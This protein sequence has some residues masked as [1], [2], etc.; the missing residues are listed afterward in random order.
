MVYRKSAC[1]AWATFALLFIT[2]PA[3]AKEEIFVYGAQLEEFE[4]RRGSGSSNEKLLAWDGGAFAG[5]DDGK[6]HWLTEGAYDLNENTFAETENRLVAQIP[7]SMFFDVKAGV[8]LDTYSGGRERWYTVFGATGLAPQ[9][10]EL[11]ADLFIGESGRASTRL[12]AEYELLLTNR[13]FATFSMETTYSFAADK[14]VGIGT[15]VTDLEAGMR[16]SYD[17]IDRSVAPYIGVVYEKKYGDT[18]AMAREEGEADEE[19]LFVAGVRLM[20]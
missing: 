19:W 5:N 13:L 8:R 10:F 1:Y 11:D 15:G 18:G 3:A 12:D 4:Y 7:V 20:L 16:L 6:I 14:K 17:V 2:M 9:W